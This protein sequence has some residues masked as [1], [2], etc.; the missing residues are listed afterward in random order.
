MTEEINKPKNKL[1]ELIEL[2]S[3][4]AE[5]SGY[6]ADLVREGNL[7]AE[8]SKRAGHLFNLIGYDSGSLGALITELTNESEVLIN[9]KRENMWNAALRI[10][11]DKIAWRGVGFCTQVVLRAIGQLSDDIK[12]GVRDKI[13]GKLLKMAEIKSSNNIE[14]PR[15]FIAHGGKSGVLDK[16]REFIEALGI[17][18]II[19]E[20]SASKGMS[21]D[22]KVNKYI[23]DAD[24]GIV[25]ATG[26]G[27][28]DISGKKPKQHPRLNVI[29]ELER[30]RATFPE[31]TIL[32]LEKGVDLPSNLSGLTR[33]EFVRQSMDRAFIAIA[34]E[35]TEMKI[36]KAVKP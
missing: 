14:S 17:K 36:L 22:E 16:L 32:L 26:G 20:L 15:A 1:D 21:V 9:D 33:E 25:L 34:R 24:C 8:K 27:I 13:S 7:T 5:Y 6:V 3:N 28:V 18:P 31:K 10:P 12:N 11:V 35:L 4:L 23:K 30:L 29:D 19:V 2:S